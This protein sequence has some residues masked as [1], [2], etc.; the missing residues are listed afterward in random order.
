MEG[1][2]LVVILVF[3]LT[4]KYFIKEL[5][6]KFNKLLLCFLAIVSI[7]SYAN[8][9]TV[10]QGVLFEGFTGAKFSYIP[11]TEEQIDSTCN[12]KYINSSSWS[13]PAHLPARDP[14]SGSDQYSMKFSYDVPSQSADFSCAIPLTTAISWV[15]GELLHQCIFTTIVGG[16]GR[17][18][19]SVAPTGD[20]IYS[21]NTEEKESYIIAES[22]SCSI[23]TSNKSIWIVHV[24]K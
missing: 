10:K 18:I 7:T 22:S 9:M 11:P 5:S 19:K 1:F 20:P 13:F 17:V 23:D 2:L 14:E 15:S 12:S 24:K 3:F 8:S 21:F 16:G 4:N 6:M